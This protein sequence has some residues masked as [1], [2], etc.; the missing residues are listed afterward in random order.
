M[1]LFMMETTQSSGWGKE[2]FQEPL[3]F[4]STW[5]CSWAPQSS[6]VVLFPWKKNS[7]QAQC[8]RPCPSLWGWRSLGRTQHFCGYYTE[9]TGGGPGD[10]GPSWLQITNKLLLC[11]AKPRVLTGTRKTEHVSPISASHHWLPLKSRVKFKTLLLKY[12]VLNY[13]APSY[14]KELFTLTLLTYL[15]YH[16]WS[17]LSLLP[18]AAKRRINNY[19]WDQ[20]LQTAVMSLH[21]MQPSFPYS[22]N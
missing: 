19:S 22:E 14:V 6:E 7:L 8:L 4:H 2:V 3:R 10:C 12:K 21:M 11:K 20:W 17:L 16:T 9:V 18:L 1:D 13:K 15:C 5:P